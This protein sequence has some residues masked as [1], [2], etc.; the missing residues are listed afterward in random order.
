MPQL[1]ANASAT[2]DAP[3]AKVYAII[4]DYKSGHPSILPPHIFKD[5]SV[6]KGGVGAG[7][8]I[9]FKMTIMGT[10][11]D[12]RATVTEPEPGRV[13]V[14]TYEGGEVTTFTVEPLGERQTK[15]TIQTLW[16]AGWF[17]GLIQRLPAPK[18]L[19]RVYDEELGNLAR[20]ARESP[21]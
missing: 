10:T 2:I 7:T 3:A 18:I 13:L 4:A 5:L 12:L 8:V 17:I 19:R 6:E 15:V 14:E 11:R 16:Q 1:K 9:R 21:P 20:V